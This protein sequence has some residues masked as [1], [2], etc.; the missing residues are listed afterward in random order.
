MSNGTVS[1]TT[2]VPPPVFSTVGFQAPS[3]PAILTGV[4]QDFSAAFNAALNFNLNTP[5]GQLVSSEAAII[6]QNYAT[7]V[8]WAQQ[9]DPAY[10]Q[11]RSQ[12][13]IGRIYFMTRQPATPT[14]L[15]INCVGAAGL[16]IPI[17]ATISD[18]SG[19]LYQATSALTIPIAGNVTGSFAC[20]V[21]GPIAVPTV[22]QVSI[23]QAISGWNSVTVVS[24]IQGVNVESRQAFETRRAASVAGNSL[25]PIGAIIGAVAGVPGVSDYFGYNNN[26]GAP[27]TVQGVTIAANAIYIAVVGGSTSA[28]AQAILSKK[29]AGAPMTGNTTVTAFDNNPLYPSPISY[30][31]TFQIP[32]PLQLLFSVTLVN[33]ASLPSNAAALVQAALIQAATQGTLVTNPA[34]LVTGLRARI[35]NI[36]YAPTYVPAINALG[37]WAQV[38]S[39]SIGSANSPG[40]VIL[41]HIV[42]STMVVQTTAGTV[43]GSIALTG[44]VAA[45]EF[46]SDPIGAIT[47]GTF[48]VA[49]ATSTWTL[50][51]AVTVAGAVVTVSTLSSTQVILTSVTGTVGIGNVL[52]ST[53][54]IPFGAQ[55][56]SQV[57]GTVGGNGTYVLSTSTTVTT[58]VVTANSLISLATAALNSVAVQINQEPQV[59]AV[60]IV[61]TH[62]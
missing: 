59:V 2:N 47:N 42:G 39:I 6:A 44:P 32:A 31:I 26:T 33:S 48:V 4:Q 28:I 34:Q 25:G 7:F 53:A 40:A 46:L 43:G 45:G 30:S 36:I 58:I 12:D 52:N 54:G 56:V 35:G 8:Y 60:N 3:G 19:N 24:G 18:S 20:T 22:N 41:G 55:I 17:G 61:V 23:Y 51:N 57:T 37:S 14:T 62:S 9:T 29:G 16:V 10:A 49:G 50:N 21:D 13:G 38:A 1:V 11:G 5:Q 27:V 15:Q